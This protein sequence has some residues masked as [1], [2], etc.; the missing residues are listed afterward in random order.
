MFNCI[1]KKHRAINC[2]SKLSCQI[3]NKKNQTSICDSG[4]QV[5][6]TRSRGSMAYPLI[7]MKVEGIMCKVLFDTGSGNSYVSAA[8]ARKV[9][10]NT[11]KEEHKKS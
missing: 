3:Y 7:V 10:K 8:L 9:N 11:K 1:G 5:I 2:I 4:N 6:L